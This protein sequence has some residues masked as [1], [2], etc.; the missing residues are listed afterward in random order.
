MDFIMQTSWN[1]KWV[2]QYFQYELFKSEI[3]VARAD[4]ERIEWVKE[5]E[6][7]HWRRQLRIKCEKLITMSWSHVDA[8]LSAALRVIVRLACMTRHHFC[9]TH[10]TVCAFIQTHISTYRFSCLLCSSTR[11]YCY[12]FLL[13]SLSLP[14]IYVCVCVFFLFIVSPN[15]CFLSL[16]LSYQGHNDIIYEVNALALSH[17]LN[18]IHNNIWSEF[19]QQRQNFKV[20]LH[21]WTISLMGISNK[22]KFLFLYITNTVVSLRDKTSVCNF[23][24]RKSTDRD[25]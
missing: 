2:R 20:R 18:T 3:G 10:L 22:T 23:S 6:R 9:Y 4:R 16:F 7:E 12:Y 15:R 11:F 19:V 25:T 13:L 1:E 8:F 14:C 17:S 5:R 21:V 24:L